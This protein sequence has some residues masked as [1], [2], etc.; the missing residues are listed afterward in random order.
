MMRLKIR[1]LLQKTYWIYKSVSIKSRFIQ[2]VIPKYTIFHADLYNLF[3]VLKRLVRVTFSIKG[4][5]K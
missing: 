2:V 3:R 4:N 5:G 1:K